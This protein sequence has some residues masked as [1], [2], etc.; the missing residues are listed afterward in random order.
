MRQMRIF[1]DSNLAQ[2]QKDVNDWLRKLGDHI[3]VLQILQSEAR[4]ALM[5]EASY[6]E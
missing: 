2:L 3:N 1:A 5:S 4:P 6:G